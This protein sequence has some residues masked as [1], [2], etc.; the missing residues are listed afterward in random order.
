M[1]S[2]SLVVGASLSLP[3]PTAA[4][5]QLLELICRA[6]GDVPCG[7][8]RRHRHDPGFAE[9]SCRRA[10]D[11]PLYL[12]R[13]QMALALA[14]RL[15][16]GGPDP[17]MPRLSFDSDLVVELEPGGLNETDLL[18]IERPAPNLEKFFAGILEDPDA[19]PARWPYS[20]DE[21]RA[22]GDRRRRGGRRR[23]RGRVRRWRRHAPRRPRIAPPRPRP[24]AR[25]R[26]DAAGG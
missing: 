23:G 15:M 18:G 13:M 2:A 1:A 17:A 25:P 22:A 16:Q 19:L 20:T 8:L 3:A 7:A 5:D 11:S 9:S 14:Q 24:A 4:C 21:A 26:R 12:G 10:L 6:G